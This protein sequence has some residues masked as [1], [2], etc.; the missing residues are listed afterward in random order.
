MATKPRRITKNDVKDVADFIKEEHK[1]RKN[2]K[3]RKDHEA[4]WKEVDRMIAMKAEE[5]K[6]ASGDPQEDW[7]ANIELG[8]LADA[9]EIITE[10][11]MRIL[12]PSDRDFFRPHANIDADLDP[13][14]GLPSIDLT[15][16]K[17][18][19]G[20]LKSLMAQQHT[21]F[22]LRYRV[23][24][25]VKEAL[26]HGSF[27]AIC[28]W[29]EQRQFAGGMVKKI[30]AP[31]WIPYSMWNCYPDDSPSV[32]GT[33]VTY[34]GSMIIEDEIPLRTAKEQ[35]WMNMKEIESSAKAD[36]KDHISVLHWYGD[37][38]INRAGNDVIEVNNQHVIVAEG[39]FAMSETNDTPF[40]PIIYSGYE[41]DDV[42]DPYYSSPLIKRAPTNKL[43]TNCANKFVDALSLR[44]KPPIGYDANE[45]SFREGGG[46]RIAPG[47]TYALRAGGSMKTIEVADPTWALQGVMLF[48]GEVEEGVGV[49]ST[50]KGTSASVEQTAFEVSKMDQKSE[51][52]TVGFVGTMEHQGVK[53]FLYM[54]HELN[55]KRLRN[56]GFYNTQ[57]ETPDF[58]VLNKDDL[59]TYAKDVHFE[60]VGSKGVLGEE[61]RRQGAMEVTA[62]FSSNEL[63]AGR[64]N[65]KEIMQDSYRDVGVKDPERYLVF[66]ED[67]AQVQAIV[68]RYE[69]TIQ[70]LQQELQK[71]QAQSLQM[72]LLK[73]KYS[74]DLSAKEAQNIA[75]RSENKMLEEQIQLLNKSDAREKQM[76]A[77]EK[78]LL[79]LRD[80]IG[81]LILKAKAEGVEVKSQLMDGEQGRINEKEGD[82]GKL[83]QVIEADR[84]EREQTKNKVVQFI[85]SKG[86]EEARNLVEGL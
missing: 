39:H 78:R 36:R 35:G 20:I 31:A 44:T 72:P 41:R 45:P 79:V 4:I 76:F 64:L 83:L 42:Q 38:Y 85:K 27:V 23:E 16:Q 34:D 51:I 63:F 17:K 6:V 2:L 74:A 66:P 62:F 56:Y 26:H 24:L 68:Q 81:D 86:S 19:D 11:V 5:G 77:A 47:E 69:A 15:K 30:G 46:P 75:M 1:R 33:N 71:A 18:V 50:R 84:A 25:S 82:I 43:A 49:D 70:A 9:S 48:K 14:T 37:I 59:N 13:E 29:E 54:Q 67:D 52:R 7:E 8:S 12:F 32:I 80:Q 57:I 58:L 3:Y 60:V 55:K 53:P 61:R 10:D 40:S 21:D 65:V 28:R 22:G 73:A